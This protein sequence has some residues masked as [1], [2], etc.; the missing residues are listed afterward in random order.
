MSTITLKTDAKNSANIMI[1]RRGAGGGHT[2]CPTCGQTRAA[3]YRRLVDGKIVE[4]CIDA[5]HTGH[6][7]PISASSEWHDRPVARMMRA[8]T[9]ADLKAL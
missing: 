1:I 5:S 8:G 4:G 9:L 2:H 3:P 7:V 6:L